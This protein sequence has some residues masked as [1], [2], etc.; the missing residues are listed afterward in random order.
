[1]LTE[2]RPLQLLNALSPIVVTE[3]GMVMLVSPL[4]L[5]NALLPI[6]MTVLGI[7]TLLILEPLTKLSGNVCTWLPIVTV[8]IFDFGILPI[9]LHSF[10]FHVNVLI[11]AQLPKVLLPI[12]ETLLGIVMLVKPNKP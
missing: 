3:L 7:V 4:Q 5:E 10:A 8:S 12:V 6:E 1:M 11:P 2:V 9:L